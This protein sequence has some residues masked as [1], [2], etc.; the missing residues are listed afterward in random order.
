MVEKEILLSIND[1]KKWFSVDEKLIGKPTSFVK[2]VDGVSFDVYKGEVLGLVGESGCGKTTISRSI[3]G[4]TEPTSGSIVFEG[5]ELM[6]MKKRELRKMRSE[7]QIVF[8]DPYSSLSPRMRIADTIA[9][10]ME[11][12]K[13]G[14]RKERRQRVE[15]LLE[16]VGLEKSF[17]DRYPHEFSG[18]QRQRIGIARVLAADPK[19]MICDE[20]VSALDVSV[21]SQILNLLIELKE[22]FGLTM[23]FISH[24]LSVVE[25]ICDRIIVM[26][27]GKVME[28]AKRDDLYRNPSHPYTQALL[29][30][31]PIPDPS[32]K[33]ERI[34][35]E[36]DTPS[37]VD[38]PAGCRF[39]TRCAK[40]QEIC[41][42][43]APELRDI[44][45]GHIVA[46]HLA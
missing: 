20:P 9:E 35:L 15:E 30:A 2:A 7:L 45:E 14:T 46:C 3:L 28:I 31:I 22:D 43:T 25:Y 42:T 19:F 13:K 27:L 37:P 4:L 11:I 16:I 33:K 18:G 5:K 17:A 10:P 34:L 23:L 32:L 44:E 1:I 29:S 26:Y 41:R 8:Q 24:D 36:G 40:A 39:C 21:R 12:Q 38:P 6:G